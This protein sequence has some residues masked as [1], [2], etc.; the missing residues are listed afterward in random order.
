[1]DEATIV[2]MLAGA[3]RV[4]VA[5][6]PKTGKTTLAI[7]LGKR[8]GRQTRHSDSLV[9]SHEWGDDS[10]EVARWLD[11]PGEWIVE[12]VT[13]ARAL[14]KWLARHESKAPDV[15]VIYCREPLISRSKGQETMAKGV[16]TVWRQVQ[17]ELRGL[18]VRIIERD[19]LRV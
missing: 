1:M 19:A 2:S 6:G 10:A 5:G 8:L 16:E 13:M 3:S 12:G 9:M 14:R 17:P 4:V 11:E 15:T 7:R 18:G